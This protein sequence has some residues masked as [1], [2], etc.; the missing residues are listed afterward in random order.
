MNRPLTQ[1]RFIRGVAGNPMQRVLR[2]G[3]PTHGVKVSPAHSPPP[4]RRN[5]SAAPDAP[6]RPVG[7]QRY[8]RRFRVI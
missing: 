8:A 2:V 4:C 3:R 6:R 7:H 5:R 1:V